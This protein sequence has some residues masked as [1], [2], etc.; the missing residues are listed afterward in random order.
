M[1]NHPSFCIEPV[2]DSLPKISKVLINPCGAFRAA[3]KYLA[4][5]QVS[6]KNNRHH[7]CTIPGG[8]SAVPDL[9][10]QL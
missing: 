7:I 3:I 5:C 8:Q 6:S 1:S 9:K 4:K 2:F 10:D